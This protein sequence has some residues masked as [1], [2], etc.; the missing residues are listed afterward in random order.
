M[1]QMIWNEREEKENIKDHA[2]RTDR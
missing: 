2:L 1:E